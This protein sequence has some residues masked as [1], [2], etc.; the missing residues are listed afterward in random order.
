M[1]WKAFSVELRDDP[2]SFSGKIEF[3]TEIQINETMPSYQSGLLDIPP[4]SFQYGLH[5]LVF[6]YEVETH[7]PEVEM[8]R[9]AYTYF[10]VT[11]G[12]LQA[13]VMA[14]SIAKVSRGWGQALILPAQD[15]SIDPDWPDETVRIFV[16][17]CHLFRTLKRVVLIS[18]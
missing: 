3:L 16:I 5:K 8:F 2:N 17:F 10:N 4:L 6:K 11:K 18:Q 15:L 13:V 9:E 1:S 14:G 12:D 7:H